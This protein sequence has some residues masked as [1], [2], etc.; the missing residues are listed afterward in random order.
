MPSAAMALVV[1]TPLD[2][3]HLAPALRA[4]VRDLDKE[5]PMSEVGTLAGNIAHST[6][7]RRLSV[8]LLGAFAL[9]AL[10]LASVGIYGVISYSVARRTHEIGVRIALGAARGRIASRV[11]GSAVLLG[12][13]GVAIG[14]AGSLVLTRLLRS[15]LYGVSATDPALFAA[16]AFF[17]LAVAAL[18]AFFPARRAA[19]VD[20]LI[21]LRNE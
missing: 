21:A 15:M 11:V 10:V 5:L 12:A 17:L 8:T 14:I 6:S 16:S 9:L 7:T 3:L 2:P 20:P 18:A 1:R 4:V 13:L 19:R